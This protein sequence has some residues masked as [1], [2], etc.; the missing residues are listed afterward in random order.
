[1][2]IR[3]ALHHKTVYRYDRRT[4]LSPQIVRLRPA[5]HCRTAIT[6]YSLKIEPRE[7]FINWQ[8]D[9]HSN[10]LAR[11]VFPNQ[12][13]SFSVEVDLVAEMKVINPF[14]YFLE[15]YAEKFPFRYE[16]A[17]E[18][19]LTPYLER[20]P[21]GPRLRAFLDS[22]DRAEQGTND[23]LVGLDQR[24]ARE[25]RY[26]IRLEPGIQTPE[27]TLTLASGSCR[28]SAWLLVQILRHLGLAA[29]FVSG[30]LIQLKPDVKPLEGPEGPAADFTDLHAWAEVYLPGAGWIGLDPTSGLFAGEGH[31]P[32]AATPDASSAAPVSGAVDPC[33][34]SFHH[35]MSVAR[36]HED[37]RVTQ[38]YTDDQWHR[39]EAMGDRIDADLQAGDVRLTMGGEPTFV[40][41]DNMDGDEWNTAAIGPEKRVLSERLLDRLRERFAPGGFLHYGQGKWY[42]G[43]QLP[44]WALACYWRVDGVPIWHD[45]VLLA[46]PDRD[47]G[48]GPLEAQRFAAALTRRLGLDPEY[49]NTAFEDPLYYLHRERQ[50]PINVGPADNRLEDATERDRLRRV[51]ERSLKTA[52]GYVLPL[53]RAAG[54]EGPEWQSGL[55]MLRGHQL[56]LLPGDS[57]IG[58]RLPLPS[59]PWAAPEEVPPIFPLDPMAPMAPLPNDGAQAVPWPRSPIGSAAQSF[60]PQAPAPQEQVLEA[61]VLQAAGDLS[62]DRPRDRRPALG[63]SAPWVVRTALCVEPRDGR[64]H[65]FMPPLPLIDD[66]L[67]LITAIEGTAAELKMPV[68]IEGY[69]P[70]SDCRI[71]RLAVTPDPGVIE[72]NVH[73][74]RDWRELVANTTA[75]YEDARQC[76]LGTEKFMLDGRHTGTGGG[77]HLTLG[78][79]TAADSPFLRRPDLLRSML[80]Y[81]L[82]HPSLSYMF[83]GMF[84]GPTSQA[85]RVDETRADSI[86][87]LE[88]A[89]GQ[90]PNP[91][92]G[93]C[94]PWI[95][96]RIFRHILVDLTGNTHRAEFCIDKL[97]SPDTPTGRLG[98]IE[99]RG[100]EM[101]PHARMSLTQQLLVRGLVAWFWRE[102]YMRKPIAWGTQLHDQ[103][104]LPAFVA[105]DFREVLDDL[106]RAGYAFEADWFASHFEFRYPVFGRVNHAGIELEIRQAAEPW[107]VLGEEPGGGATARYVDSSVERIQIKASGLSSD[108]FLVT[109]NGRRIPLH[110]TGTHGQ[111]VAGVRYRAWQPPS[112]LHPTIPVHA[113][114]VFD[115]VDTWTGRSL[116]GCTYHVAHPG[117]RHYE[118]VPI[119]ANEAEARRGA[120][121][122]PFGHTPGPMAIPPP[123]PNAQFPLTLDL[124]RPPVNGNP[125]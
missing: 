124:R 119:N 104:M 99:M 3:V 93:N 100:F 18:R 64:L 123:E 36:I 26:L 41:I 85:P 60:A 59:L 106:G 96:D 54:R 23:F 34:V 108:R 21:A 78:A 57:P 87:E 101:P 20:G 120:R 44:R 45:R 47:Y 17:I 8:Q 12:T 56:F 28:D 116:G 113:P 39:I 9:P 69:T 105:R 122:F 4:S 89:F 97:Y 37:P 102:P 27:E 19:E 76:R 103:F 11:L 71:N 65:V 82:N 7:H 52:A 90:V 94:P 77:N 48:F 16:A 91:G 80:G 50:L 22:I 6:A 31:I 98:L 110:F 75:L 29:R 86:Y 15:P 14:D 30:Y 40:S 74:A 88:I 49:L 13:T 79:A 24:L 73:P 33:E 67:D 111:W 32:L 92:E 95:V 55:W 10:Y 63:E 43:E 53:Q 109:C 66:Y 72:V 83:S 114:L 112:C 84:I 61:Q 118:A 42:P 2:S 121:F 5:P 107:Y 35:E 62:P 68:V 38:P 25:I 46:S 51:F 70:P 1:V 117:G 58:L 81:W 115:I 125:F